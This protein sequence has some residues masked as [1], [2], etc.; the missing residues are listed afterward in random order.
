VKTLTAAFG[1]ER[2]MYGGGFGANAT[3][4]SY[5]AERD[6]VAGFLA[7]LSDADRT[8]VLGGTAAKLFKLS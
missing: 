8:Q 2:L 6:R 4:A 1:A 3:G 5:K 7:H